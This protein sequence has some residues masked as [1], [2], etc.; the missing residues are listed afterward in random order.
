MKEIKRLT[1]RIIEAESQKACNSERLRHNYNFHHSYDEKVQRMLNILQPGTYIQ[2]HRHKKISDSD[3][4]GF[5]FLLVIQGEIGVILFNEQGKAIYWERLSSHGATLG[6]EIPEDIYHTVL[7]LSPNT[8]ILEFKEGPF[9]VSEVK[10][11]HIAFPEEGTLA[12]SQQVENW[13]QHFKKRK[14]VK[15]GNS[16]ICT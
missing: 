2:P 8:A 5:E 6:L 16:V 13:H 4:D 12:A 1:K 3:N 10:D 7:S 9:I 15:N 11:L 14:A